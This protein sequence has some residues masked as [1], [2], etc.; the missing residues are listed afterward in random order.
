MP[1]T[2][3]TLGTSYCGAALMLRG[4]AAVAAAHCA[5]GCGATHIYRLWCA[6]RVA[7][8]WRRGWVSLW[9]LLVLLLLLLMLLMMLVLLSSLSLFVVAVCVITRRR[10]S[11]T[12][13]VDPAHYSWSVA[14]HRTPTHR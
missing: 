8:V 13:R 4:P 2:L 10:R 3:N 12:A 6:V 9:L 1:T 7:I 11:C 14:Q 5:G